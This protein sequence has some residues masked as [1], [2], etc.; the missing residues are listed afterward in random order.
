MRLTR[1]FKTLAG[2]TLSLLSASGCTAEDGTGYGS[3]EQA[4][5]AAQLIPGEARDLG[6]QTILTDQAYRVKLD[7]SALTFSGVA[8]EE[9]TA[10]GGGGSGASFDP[11]NPP[12]GYSLCH[13]GHCHHDDGRLVDYE[14]IEIELAGSGG[15]E[16]VAVVTLHHDAPLDLWSPARIP[17]RRF[18]PSPELPQTTLRKVSARLARFTVAG[19]VAGGPAG[20]GIGDTAVPFSVDLDLGDATHERLTSLVIDREAPGEFQVHIAFALNGTL[21]DDIDFA[22]LVDGGGVAIVGPESKPGLQLARNFESS[23][24]TVSIAE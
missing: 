3:I 17:V 16:F 4:T 13:S 22:P 8:L 5:L 10:Q 7:K 14:D 20:T 24:L 21:F 23:E 11:A 19:S 15:A 1:A 9:L 18:D 2:A 6:N 12:P